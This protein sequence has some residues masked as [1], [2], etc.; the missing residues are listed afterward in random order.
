MCVVLHLCVLVSWRLNSSKNWRWR[1]QTWMCLNLTN[2][3][4]ILAHFCDHTISRLRIV[5]SS[6][7]MCQ[8]PSCWKQETASDWT[9]TKWQGH[10]LP[11]RL[12]NS[13][14]GWRGHWTFVFPFLTKK[15]QRTLVATVGSL[16]GSPLK[17]VVSVISSNWRTKEYCLPRQNFKAMQK[18][19]MKYQ[20]FERCSERSEKGN[21]LG[22]M[23]QCT[24]AK[25]VPSQR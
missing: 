4:G 9:E 23:L 7:T 13:A 1:L 17:Q 3:G 22:A 10:V 18:V 15:Q 14:E 21:Q 19:F 2:C 5:I 25:A 6:L 8:L 12:K 16:W 11:D 24:S 20:K